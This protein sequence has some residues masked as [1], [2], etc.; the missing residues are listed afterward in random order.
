MESSQ[1]HHVND[2]NVRIINNMFTYNHNYG[3]L[4]N[5]YKN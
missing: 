1:Q 5:I 2:N 3:I 4:D